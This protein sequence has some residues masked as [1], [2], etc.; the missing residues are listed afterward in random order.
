MANKAKQTSN[1]NPIEAAERILAELHA[2]Q[3]K[4]VKAREA[5]DRELGSVSYAA[6]AA[7]DKDAAEKLER[8]KDLA[9]RRDL[10]IKA[11][12]SAIA[13]AQHNLA[14]AKADE[15]AAEQKRCAGEARVIVDRID[16][17]F[18]S[19]DLHFKQAMD[20]LLAAD[21]RIDEL[22]QIGFQYPT[23]VQLRANIVYALETC[24]T[25]LPKYL[26][27]ELSR[28]GLRYPSPG[29]RR[30]FSKFW[31]DMSANLGREIA[32]RLGEKPNK[33]VA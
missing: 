30:T 20:A 28:G 10:E 31:T 12:R 21:K 9:L 23:P 4:T 16:S 26:W 33:E 19:A 14:E 24:M 13:Q 1:E 8:V 3:D 5:D 15:A 11:I 6:L 22:H 27:D 18:A 25:A 2:Q 29:Q 17:L 7:G 32:N